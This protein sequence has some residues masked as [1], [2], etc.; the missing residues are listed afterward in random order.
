MDLLGA[1]HLG[2]VND[3][4]H[5]TGEVVVVRVHD[6]GV[7]GHL[8]A[9]EGA[10]GLLAALRDALHNLCHVLGAQL[11]DGHVVQEEER[12]GTDGHDVVHA[13]GHQVLAHRVMA[14]KQL[15]DG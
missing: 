7:L 6:A 14:V 3:A 13:H 9:D 15:S 11:A 1:D 8:S 12:L 5:E 10:A 2:A 4:H